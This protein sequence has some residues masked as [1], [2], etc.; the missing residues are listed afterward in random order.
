MWT[1]KENLLVDFSVRYEGDRYDDDLNTIR[2][3]SATVSDLRV[4]YLFGNG[5]EGFI[6]GQNIFDEAVE[7]SFTSGATTYAA[8]QTWQI[9][10]RIRK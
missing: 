7:S 8:P 4:S 2:L 6:Q 9:G 3:K 1:P 10:L 5:V